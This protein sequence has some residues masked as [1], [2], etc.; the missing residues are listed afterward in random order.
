MNASTYPDPSARMH[1]TAIFC[2]RGMFRPH[3]MITGMRTSTPSVVMLSTACA[4]AT[5]LRH[6]LL[7]TLSG[8]HGPER[9]AVKAIVSFFGII[10]V[11]WLPSDWSSSPE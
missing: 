5:L 8:L 1:P 9:T 11:S 10:P 7:P 3:S 6:V 2:F 4:S